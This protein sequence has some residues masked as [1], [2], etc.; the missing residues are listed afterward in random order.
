PARAHT[1]PT[2]VRGKPSARDPRGPGALLLVEDDPQLNQLA[3]SVLTHCGYKV[4]AAANPEEGL[5]LCRTHLHEIHLLVTDV[6][7]PK[8]N[9]PPLAEEVARIRPR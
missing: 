9:G 6:V 8:M 4:L 2:L 5:A 1:T 7:M 3:S